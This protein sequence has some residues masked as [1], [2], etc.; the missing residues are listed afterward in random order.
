MVRS[1]KVTLSSESIRIIVLV[2][3]RQGA[4]ENIR[5]LNQKQINYHVH[6]LC[7]CAYAMN[8]Q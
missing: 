1:V 6:I 8:I 3:K 5:N 2:L 7:E 4:G